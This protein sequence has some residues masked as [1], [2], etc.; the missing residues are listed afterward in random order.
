MKV[1]NI[2]KK[3]LISKL[4]IMNVN[5][6]GIYDNTVIVDS[7]L[8][9]DV[10]LLQ[11]GLSSLNDTLYSVVEGLPFKYANLT[12]FTILSDDYDEHKINNISSISSLDLDINNL[13]TS[14]SI[15][16]SDINYN[17]VNNTTL[18]TL[19]TAIDEQFETTTT[20]ID[21]KITEQHEY[22]D[23]EIE[24]LR[25]EGYIQEAVTQ[26]LAWIT[27][28]EGKR[29][30]KKVWDRIKNKWLSFTGQR[31]FTELLDDVENAMSDELD[32][33]LKVYKYKDDAISGTTGIAGIRSEP[34]SGK[35]ICM[36]GDTYIYSGN[37]Y[38]TGD[39]N[40]GTFNS[41]NGTW[42]QQEKLN[43][44]FVM[45]GVK[46]SHCLDINDTTKLIELHYD[47]LDFELGPGPYYY[48]KLKY[49]IHS[50]H[51]TQC[52][53]IDPSTKQLEF[54]INTD[55]FDF[56]SNTKHSLKPK[57]D[58][59]GV[60]DTGPLFIDFSTR[61]L[62]AKYNDTLQ[63]NSSKE[64]G[65]TFDCKGVK[66]SNFL[67][68]D[69]TTKLLELMVN[70]S[71]FSSDSNGDLTL[72]LNPSGGLLNNA[73]GTAIKLADNSLNLSTSGL[74]LNTGQGLMNSINGVAVKLADTSLDVSVLG[75]QIAPTYKT[76][77]Q[78]IKAQ[79]EA[80]KTG[81]DT[82]KTGA[83]AA[84]TGADAAKAAA[85]AAKLTAISQAELAT[86]QA[87]I[88]AEQAGS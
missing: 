12:S 22:T 73:S 65:T 87:G 44:Y 42:T 79:A 51:P 72:K 38:L 29:F 70:I 60:E 62:R 27:S 24:A 18:S 53:S 33:M 48:L 10:R 86:A 37:L 64:L 69:T 76:E 68:V 61:K 57:F 39:I 49:P 74:Q 77:L 81:A 19:S 9:D 59:N 20:Y 82:A 46:T 83:D 58:C 55:Y 25:N 28:D 6:T 35:E 36:K 66:S 2:L 7:N 84:K 15:L 1:M 23:Q 56:E 14:I 52:L 5:I 26:L 17:Y 63:V 21:D 75:L 30:R 41:T 50:V 31:P 8:F 34:F 47:D 32:E 67:K 45:K 4:Y 54:N 80:A 71:H 40:K 85:E 11:T 88:A 16:S 43:D 3:N 78:Q 13:S